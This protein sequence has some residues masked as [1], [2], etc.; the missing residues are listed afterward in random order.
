MFGIHN[1][2]LTPSLF[3]EMFVPADGA[4]SVSHVS[5]IDFEHVQT[6]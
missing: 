4:A 6:V 2:S 3:I 5:L 1:T